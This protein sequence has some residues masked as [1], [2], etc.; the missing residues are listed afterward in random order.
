MRMACF[1]LIVILIA[2]LVFANTEMGT[3]EGKVIDSLT[4]EPI[5]NVNVVVADAEMGSSTNDQGEFQIPNLTVGLHTLKAQMMG[6]REESIHNLRIRSEKVHTLHIELTQEVIELESV[7]VTA[8]RERSLVWDVPVSASIISAVDIE[9]G[10]PVTLGEAIQEVGGTF[11]KKYGTAGALETVSLRG[12]S[13]EQVLVLWD[14]QRLNSPLTGGFDLGTISLQPINKIEIIHGGYSSLYGADAMAGVV[15]LITQKPKLN[16]KIQA[17]AHTSLGSYGFQKHEVYFNQRLGNWSYMLSANRVESDGNFEYSVE[18]NS[19]TKSQNRKNA[20]LK[21]NGLFGKATWSAGPATKVH[22]QSELARVE[23]GVPGPLSYPTVNGSQEDRSTRIHGDLET[24]PISGVTIR[25]GSYYHKHDIH[26]TDEHPSYPTDSQNDAESYGLNLQ[27]NV[28]IGRQNFLM[29]GSYLVE[30]G[31]GNNVG[32]RERNS[33]ALFGQGEFEVQSSRMFGGLRTILMP[34]IRYDHFS[35]FGDV[36]NPR[37]GFLISKH[38]TLPAGLWLSWGKAFRAPTVNDLYWPEDMF[39]VGNPHLK[40]EKAT[41]YE[42]GFRTCLPVA[43]GLELKT[44]YFDKDAKDLILWAM[45]MGSGKW[46]PNNVSAAQ[47]SGVEFSLSWRGIA[48]IL[49][50]EINYTRLNSKNRSGVAGLD[51]KQLPYRPKHSGSFIS[52]LDIGITSLTFT[53]RYIGGRFVDESNLE[54]LESHL[55]FDGDIGVKRIIA[56]LRFNLVVSVQNIFNKGYKV[57]WDYPMPGRLWR[58]KMGLDL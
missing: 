57:V 14:G 17:A 21:S 26:Y 13:S 43:D 16:G 22:V 54:Q 55:L 9:R 2:A 5:A 28:K 33:T 49:N 50:T 8:T 24:T 36:I 38:G 4:K 40:P 15:N 48:K 29:G 53:T 12:S 45:D 10:N 51:G 32:K 11:V 41:S 27:S 56:G 52:G 47:I 42:I 35:D 30:S 37:F 18:N 20:N 31:R 46:M 3:I 44:C 19:Q 6:Y 34:S 1:C 39:T 25:A 7:T 58:V 23:R